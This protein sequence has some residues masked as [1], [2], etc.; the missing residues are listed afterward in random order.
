MDIKIGSVIISKPVWLGYGLA[1]LLA[2]L[3]AILGL[4]FLYFPGISLPAILLASRATKQFRIDNGDED[5]NN[6][7]MH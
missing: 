5:G 1:F 3:P 4:S 6:T 7:P 2:A